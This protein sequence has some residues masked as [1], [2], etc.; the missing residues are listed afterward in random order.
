MGIGGVGAAHGARPQPGDNSQ[1]PAEQGVEV[2]A[3]GAHFGGDGDCRVE[4][5][6]ALCRFVT[7]PV[8]V[9][10]YR[11][12]EAARARPVL[13]HTALFFADGQRADGVDAGKA[14]RDVEHGFVDHYRNGVEVAGVSGK[15]EALR[16]QRQRAATGK[17]VME[18]GQDVGIEEGGGLR[19]FFVELAGLAPARPNG[20]VGALEDVGVVAV[21]PLHQLTDDVEQLLAADFGG[22]F[23][24]AAPEALA[25]FVAR[26]VHHLREDHGAGGGKRPPRPPQVQGAGMSVADGFFARGSAVDV[27]QR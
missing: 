1:F 26:V 27:I 19:V 6:D 18:G 22:F 10:A 21:F 17:G 7:H 13:R 23:V 11:L 16:F 2:G 9:A 12:G 4:V 25:G 20:V 24:D 3:R 15:A 8:A 14:R 5:A